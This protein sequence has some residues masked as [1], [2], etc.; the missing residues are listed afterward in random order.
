[1]PKAVL[2]GL[3]E[4]DVEIFSVSS[5]NDSGGSAGEER[6]SYGTPVAYGDIR[7]AAYQLSG[8]PVHIKDFLNK[9]LESDEDIDEAIRILPDTEDFI[10]KDRKGFIGH[11]LSNIASTDTAVSSGPVEAIEELRKIYKIPQRFHIL[12][13]TISDSTLIA[14]LENG[15]KIIGE[16]NIDIPEHNPNLKIKK[17]FF[18][19]PADAYP[20]TIEAIEGADLIII[21]PGDLYSSLAQILLVKGV[22]EAVKRSKAKKI[23]ICNLMQKR[24]ETAGFDVE[25]FANEIERYLGAKLDLVIYNKTQP[26]KE[27][28]EDYKKE[29]PELM[30]MVC[31]R[32]LSNDEKFIGEGVLLSSGPVVHD[33][34]KLIKVIQK[35]ASRNF[36]RG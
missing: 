35:Y 27:R 3:K 20:P 23:Y 28:L 7:R 31:F 30:D 14:E 36:G 17:V 15:E 33:S 29:R 1:M 16:A 32:D 12:P 6:E 5:M 24:G 22:P 13:A 19:P 25:D 18:E 21:G 8:A 2:E 10:N 9:R 34:K 26:S 11:V 4:I